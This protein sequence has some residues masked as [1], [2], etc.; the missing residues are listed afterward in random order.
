MSSSY[1]Y[2]GKLNTE[3]A[4]ALSSKEPIS[5]RQ[6]TSVPGAP[7]TDLAGRQTGSS[8]QTTKHRI[9]RSLSICNG[10]T[11]SR[12]VHPFIQRVLELW[13]RIKV[14]VPIEIDLRQRYSISVTLSLRH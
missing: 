6:V 7:I 3:G 2:P 4:Q 8:I 10:S 1:P 14:H 5:V 11:A 13:R 9:G 12:P